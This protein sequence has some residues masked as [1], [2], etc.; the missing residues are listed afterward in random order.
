MTQTVNP[1][2]IYDVLALKDISVAEITLTKICN[3]LNMPA[4]IFRLSDGRHTDNI[5]VAME[6]LRKGSAVT[7]CGDFT[8]VWKDGFNISFEVNGSNQVEKS[9]YAAVLNVLISKLY[10]DYLSIHALLGSL[11][12][13]LMIDLPKVVISTTPPATFPKMEIII[14]GDDGYHEAEGRKT[15]WTL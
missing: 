4:N 15:P 13:P 11:T 6:E 3:A 10:A 2:V 7:F 1:G 14:P 5:W 9:Y 8:M 12:Q